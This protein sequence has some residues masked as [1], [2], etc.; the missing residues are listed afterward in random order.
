MADYL[1]FDLAQVGQEQPASIQAMLKEL[2][3]LFETGE[4]QPLPH[5]I[6]PITEAID[7]FRYMQQA[8]HIGKIVLTPPVEAGEGDASAPPIREDGAY[9]IT[10]GLGALGL[11][12]AR[13]MVGEGARHLVLTGRRAPSEEAQSILRELEAAGAQVSVASADVSDYGRMA[14]LFEELNGQIPPLKGIIH[15]AGLLDD[16]VLEQQDMDRFRRVMAPK[17]AGSWNL[18]TLTR[19]R[20]LDFFVCFSSAASL[21]GNA[22]QGNYAAAN[23]F[24][25]ALV[26][27]RRALGLPGLS[28][29]WGAW[30]EIGLAA[31]MDRQQQNRLAA[32]GMGAIDPARGI[33][34]LAGLMAQTES[35]QV[36]VCPMNWPRFL[37][38][39]QRIPTFLSEFAHALPDAS[40]AKF[41]DQLKA[42]PPEK[43]RS[44]LTA[45]IRS[46]LN[47][48]LGF[49]PAQPMDADIGFTN[50]GMDSLMV[51]ES[52]NRLQASLGRSLSSTLLFK[53]PTL[54][55][56]VDYLLRE[57]STQG[58]PKELSTDSERTIEH[59]PTEPIAIIGMGCRFPGADNPEGYWQLLQDGVDAIGEVPRERWDIDAWFDPDPTVPG[60]TYVR[61][62]GF[63][64]G[65]DR[66][67]PQFFGISPREATDMDPQQRLLLEVSWEALE[68]AG[69]A[70]HELM[71][72]TVGV[73]IGVSQMEYG[74]M[75]LSGHPEDI[76]PYTGTGAGL[77]FTAGRLSYVLGLQGPAFAMDT[78]CSSSLVALH[79]ACQSVTSFEIRGTLSHDQAWVPDG[80]HGR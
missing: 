2:M 25:D 70:P 49:D 27:Y 57:V 75:M 14:D 33:S 56:L 23:A 35:T 76:T 6:F 41:I 50:L 62:G 71:D 67:D 22:G 21:L 9:L 66:F 64:S 4:L 3:P 77:S 29:N 20:P 44:F 53:Y 74:S 13:W 43:Q 54:D 16:G 28:L 73:F 42:T 52:R 15:A 47:R 32:M 31:E 60:K 8:R 63:L 59:S 55:S 58:S 80:A 11:E 1:P 48:V 34:I 40:S 61:R 38:Q 65:I 78:A 26:H 51:V 24:M 18:H 72:R 19:D 68:N 12:A 10:G 37:K 79:Q 30:A 69:L 39:R 46:E 17:L 5:K 45:H 7:A 36:G